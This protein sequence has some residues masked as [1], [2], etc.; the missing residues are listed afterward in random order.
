[1]PF[2]SHKRSVI[3]AQRD[4]AIGLVINFNVPV[5]KQGIRRVVL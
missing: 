1:M 2:T 5:L 4:F 3:F